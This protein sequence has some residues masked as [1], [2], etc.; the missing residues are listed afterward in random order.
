MSYQ[1][2]RH[3]K[4]GN[5]LR[6]QYDPKSCR[7]GFLRL[8]V[9]L[10]PLSVSASCGWPADGKATGANRSFIQTV[11]VAPHRINSGLTLD[12]AQCEAAQPVRIRKYEWAYDR[13]R[14]RRAR[15]C[16]THSFWALC[17]LEF[18]G[19]GGGLGSAGPLVPEVRA[20]IGEQC[21]SI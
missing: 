17:R 21:A 8:Q 13:S 15:W 18:T 7:C 16:R 2:K 1:S 4:P 6:R 20:D 3:Q 5:G 19:I 11:L 9:G 10:T 12:L 14:Y